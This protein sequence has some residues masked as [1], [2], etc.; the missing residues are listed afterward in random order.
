MNAGP[1]F[2]DPYFMDWCPLFSPIEMMAW[3]DI[4]GAGTPLYPQYPVGGV[5]VDFGNPW[6][7]VALELDGKA[8]HEGGLDRERDEKLLALGWHV[9]RVP[10]KESFGD[11]PEDVRDSYHD[12]S[13]DECNRAVSHWLLNT[14]NGLVTAIK[15][16]YF[17]PCLVNK[18]YWHS[19]DEVSL[20]ME[21]LKNHRLVSFPIPSAKR[22]PS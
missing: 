1:H 11:F 2:T 16:F 8:F 19:C 15:H 3:Y 4:R 18:S 6:A 5:F 17:A 22:A 21:S 20:G 12:R 9:Y 7:K 14:S 13:E 10:G